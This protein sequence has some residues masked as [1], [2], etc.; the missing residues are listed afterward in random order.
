MMLYPSTQP[1]VSNKNHTDTQFHTQAY[2]Y[3]LIKMFDLFQT[4]S[5]ID[6]FSLDFSHSRL[7]NITTGVPDVESSLLKCHLIKLKKG[8]GFIF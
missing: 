4:D 3:C 2:N 6:P 1:A 5:F 8:V 7:V